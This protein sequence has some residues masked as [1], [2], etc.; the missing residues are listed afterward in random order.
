MDLPS[1]ASLWLKGARLRTL[2]AAMA[3]VLAGTASG[4]YNHGGI[5]KIFV[6]RFLLAAVV[7]L[8]LQVGVNF[9]NDYSDGIR[10]TDKD[11]VGPLR[12]VG[13]GLVKPKKV[14]LAAG[15]CALVAMGAGLVLAIVV[16]WWLVAVGAFSVLAAWTYTG[17]PKP[18]GYLGLGEVFVF[19]FFGLVATLGSQYVQGHGI[20]GTGIAASISIGF[21]ACAILLTNNIRDIKGDLGSSKKTLAIFLGDFKARILYS[22]MCI[23]ALLLLI[24]IAIVTKRPLT[25]MA[26]VSAV[27]II[28]AVQIVLKGAKG[29]AL[30]SVLQKTSLAELLFGLFL[31]IGLLI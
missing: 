29:P 16:S 19:V 4:I 5:Q 18:Y 28:R 1:A 8:S 6:G 15:I 7:A 9:A 3:P 10:G 23:L 11:R 17:G 13:S 14:L 30:I 31:T 27:P 26:L 22:T 12:L 20:T 24:P 21:L 2:P 25:L